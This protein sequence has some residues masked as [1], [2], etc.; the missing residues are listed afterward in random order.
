MERIV[1]EFLELVKISSPSGGERDMADVLTKKL[2]ALGFFVTEDDAGSKTGGSA[3]NLIAR[4]PATPGMEQLAPILFSAHMDRVPDGDGIEPVFT[5]D[6]RIITDG[7]TILAADDLAGVC[8]ILDGIRR[9]RDGEH[10][11]GELEV[12]FTISE[13]V[14]LKGAKNLDYSLLHAKRAYCMDS[15]GRLGRIITGAPAI[16]RLFVTVH[17]KSSHAGASPEKGIDAIKAAAKFIAGV[18]EGRLDAE[19]TSNFG[20]IRAGKATNVICELAEITGEARSHDVDK[21]HA[22]E[23]YVKDFLKQC[24]QENGVQIDYRV[25]E[26]HG[27]FRVDFAHEVVQAAKRALRAIGV[28][29]SSEIGG[30][31]MDANLFNAH[32][33]TAVGVATGYAKNHTHQEELNLEDFLKVGSFVEQLILQETSAI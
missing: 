17:G 31:G 1:E 29:P 15:S 22:Y 5:G 32:G 4:L 20:I 25:E 14:S 9:I 10:A 8:G 7:S 24:E 6:G 26:N 30:G 28:T 12:V 19:S 3:G 18:R 13:E 33:I 2:K 16:D 11:H 21:L 23:A 27:A